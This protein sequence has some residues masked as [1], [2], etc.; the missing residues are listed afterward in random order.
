MTP[1]D[2]RWV[3][4]TIGYERQSLEIRVKADDNSPIERVDLS[5]VKFRWGDGEEFRL[6]SVKIRG[7]D[8]IL[9]PGRC[10]QI[11]Y[12]SRPDT[13]PVEG[14]TDS[15]TEAI[16]LENG[17]ERFWMPR[18][19]GAQFEVIW[20]VPNSSAPASESILCDTV[21]SSSTYFCADFPYAEP[22]IE[23]PLT[24]T[25]EVTP[26]WTPTLTVAVTPT[27]AAPALE[28]LNFTHNN[29][30]Y[31]I[32]REPVRDSTNQFINAACVR[33]EEGMTDAE[34][35]A[36]C[37]ECLPDRKPLAGDNC[38]VTAED[39]CEEII[40]PAI[41]S[42]L[43]WRVPTEE[44][45]ASAVQHGIDTGDPLSLAGMEW[46]STFVRDGFG[47]AYIVRAGDARSF[48]EEPLVDSAS[49]E[50]QQRATATAELDIS[51]GWAVFRCVAP[52]EE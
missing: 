32:L 16:G 8:P 5:R 30:D 34:R 11:Y 23:P 14:C 25:E 45:W 7:E 9:A 42:D 47:F 1:N 40:G 15:N 22:Y 26:T 48:D 46:T 27:V 24:P 43:E 3:E 12:P 44:E 41:N 6:S 38:I 36:Y 37:Y 20:A 52:L 28:T 33:L 13:H 19:G 29:L 35:K 4:L 39:Y 31:V 21:L 17:Q 50:Y 49:I 2:E 51:F 10:L 18:I